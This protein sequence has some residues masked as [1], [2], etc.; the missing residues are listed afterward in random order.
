LLLDEQ[1]QKRII[2]RENMEK[3]KEKMKREAAETQ[4]QLQTSQNDLAK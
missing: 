1:K 4:R 2:F 3:E